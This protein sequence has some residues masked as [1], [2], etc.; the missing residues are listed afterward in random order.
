MVGSTHNWYKEEIPGKSD[1]E[2]GSEGKVKYKVAS[3]ASR[4]SDEEYV[5]CNWH[6][7]AGRKENYGNGPCM[8]RM[9]CEKGSRTHLSLSVKFAEQ[10][11]TASQLL[12][13]ISSSAW[14]W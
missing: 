14:I 10:A 6:D 1:T 3:A 7:S 2:D 8:L 5:H 13:A 9:H 11:T 4:L 12:Q